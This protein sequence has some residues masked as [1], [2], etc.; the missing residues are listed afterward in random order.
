MSSTII[1]Q[2]TSTVTMNTSGDLGQSL[3]LVV[4]VAVVLTAMVV[5]GYRR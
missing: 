4:L 1:E 5:R 3:F 2:T